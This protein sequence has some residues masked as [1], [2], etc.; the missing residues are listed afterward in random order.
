MASVIDLGNNKYRLIVSNGYDIKGKRK[1]AS[2]TVEAK[3]KREAE[4]QATLL[5]SEVINGKVE[6]SNHY[7]FSQLVDQWRIYQKPQLAEKTVARYEG[8]IIDYLLP[9]FGNKLV[10]SIQPIHIEN[11]LAELR[12][13]G[14][15][16]DGKIG[17][18]SPKTIRHH[19]T[20]LSS[21]FSH[22]VKWKIIS[23]SPCSFVDAPKV[24]KTEVKYYQPEQ[25]D[26]LL[27]A[28][29]KAPMKYKVFVH[30]ALF[31][32]CRRSEIMGLEWKDID[33]EKHTFH[34]CRTS[35]YTKGKGIFSIKLLKD[36]SPSRTVTIPEGT[37]E[38]LRQY[39]VYQNKQKFNYGDGWVN[40]DRLFVQENGKPMSPDTPY[41]W[42]EGFLKVNGLPK[43]TVHQL[44]H[45]NISLMIYQG[46][47]IVTIAAE[48]GHSVYTMLN[49][50]AHVIRKAC[51]E[52][53]LKLNDEFYKKVVEKT[54]SK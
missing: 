41:Q 31:S 16:K 46:T 13:D 29:N 10:K 52:G 40:S 24:P 47:D 20:L 38:L 2:K 8:I 9:A 54:D 42:F 18:Y 25:V 27:K 44:R 35:Q 15:R 51:E 21:L 17:G 11:Y 12:K 30:V 5:E 23:E 36:G 37:I 26:T 50:Y 53:A 3:S 4:K 7:K 32:G 43:I 49:T 45:T 33:F 14:I 34:I 22:A 19:Y 1:R 6:H 39:K 28:L 48:K